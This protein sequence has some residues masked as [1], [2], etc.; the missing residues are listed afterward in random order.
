MGLVT[1]V[2]VGFAIVALFAALSA[3]LAIR[4]IDAL[5]TSMHGVLN[6]PVRFQ[7]L[8]KELQ[9]GALMERRYEK[10]IFL[11]I[12]QKERQE[13]YYRKFLSV[14][15]SNEKRIE[16]MLQLS[17]SLAAADRDVAK[18]QLDAIRELHTRYT[19]GFALVASVA[20][21]DNAVKSAELNARMEPIK[22]PIHELSQLVDSLA[23]LARTAESQS[24]AG[25]FAEA[26]QRMHI[27]W[28]V[29]AILAILGTLMSWKI[30][31]S[32]RNGVASVQKPLE[33]L[34]QN[35]NLSLRIPVVNQDEMGQIGGHFNILVSKLE[36]LIGHLQVLSGHNVNIS[37]QLTQAASTI[38]T[39]S[40]GMLKRVESSVESYTKAQQA[41]QRVLHLT[42]NADEN[43]RRS[44]EQ[45]HSIGEKLETM[46]QA[47]TSMT[48]RLRQVADSAETMQT[49]MQTVASA[50]EEMNASLS[51]VA[52][53]S[54]QASR[55]AGVAKSEVDKS[56]QTTDAL[57]AN[58]VQIGKVVELIQ[59]IA[60]QTNLLAL[61]AT[62]EAASAGE[63]G[64]GF[65]VVAGE[66]KEL[67]KQTAQATDEIR[68]R[69]LSIQQGT[70]E[71]VDSIARIAKVVDDVESLS[72]SIAAAVEEQTATTNEIGRNVV[73]VADIVSR[74]G[75]RVHDVAANTETV[76][77]EVRS[78]VG[79]VQGIAENFVKLSVELRSLGVEAE[80][81][82]QSHGLVAQN[83]AS[84]RQ[85]CEVVVAKGG[86]SRGV[87]RDM[88]ASAQDLR[89]QLAV[90]VT[91]G[92]SVYK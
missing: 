20:V 36:E 85:S 39:E 83:I 60:A 46:S 65:A 6:G 41:S 61:N 16:E 84:L 27:I 13:E 1:K 23:L 75:D 26:A 22:K 70:G 38:E 92:D 9:V 45:V 18:R 14:Q 43:G 37:H 29:L 76:I 52:G 21:S 25:A 72:S 88:E 28:G 35:W 58:A 66:V 24:T 87:A 82:E 74:V 56:R 34:L 19:D 8:A 59:G 15:D 50:I 64:K 47:V 4:G 5:E 62:I 57:G 90:F 44:A 31:R 32:L 49:G 48:E 54:A 86:E 40:H 11:N 78:T 68:Q 63:A 91:K 73:S 53:S 51:E 30:A 10:D 3:G 71:A 17:G 33:A 12:G 79:A 42:R 89:K 2:K 55:I 67:A 80:S 81:A 69:V 7:L 77:A